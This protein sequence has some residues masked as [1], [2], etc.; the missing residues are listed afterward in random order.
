[1]GYLRRKN[2]IP[3]KYGRLLKLAGKKRVLTCPL[4]VVFSLNEN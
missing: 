2:G 4:I 1:M 3:S